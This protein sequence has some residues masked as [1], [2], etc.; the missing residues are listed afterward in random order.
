MLYLCE[1]LEEMNWWQL[2][3]FWVAFALLWLNLLVTQPFLTSFLQLHL[4]HYILYLF[5]SNLFMV[6]ES[7]VYHITT[8]TSH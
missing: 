6:K 4:N 5:L 1:P 7:N 3:Y 8:F 2:T